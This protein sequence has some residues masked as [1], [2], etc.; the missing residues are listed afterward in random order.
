MIVGSLKVNNRKNIIYFYFK[1][2]IKN[3]HTDLS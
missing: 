3:K 2:K 1:N